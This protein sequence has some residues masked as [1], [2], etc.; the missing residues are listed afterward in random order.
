MSDLGDY[1]REAKQANK[2][3]RERQSILN[4]EWLL[5]TNYE[6]ELKANG[7]AVITVGNR[8][9]DFWT[10]TNKWFDRKSH[11]YGEGRCKL[12]KHIER[13]EGLDGTK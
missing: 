6:C 5:S 9:L 4:V 1:W 3:H 12:V 13:L 7:L 8:K 11:K 2:T 10:T